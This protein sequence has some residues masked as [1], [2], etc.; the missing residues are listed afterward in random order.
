[1]RINPALLVAYLGFASLFLSP[2]EG[3]AQAPSQLDQAGLRPGVAV[4]VQWI[5]LRDPGAPGG[6]SW[7]ADHGTIVSASDQFVVLDVAGNRRHVIR[8]GAITYIDLAH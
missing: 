6:G 8:W 4:N 3:W 7:L 2:G 5:W 1:M